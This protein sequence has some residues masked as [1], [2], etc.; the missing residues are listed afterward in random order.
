MGLFGGSSSSSSSLTNSITFNPNI[1]VGE[2]NTAENRS[3]QKASSE[4][5][6]TTKDEFGLSAGVAF[7]G[8]D[9]MGGAVSDTDTQ[10]MAKPQ[11]DFF[12]DDKTKLYLIGG[13]A[14]VLLFGG[15][16]L[17][18]KRKKRK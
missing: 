10:P 14:L 8:G 6:A 3:E 9:A 1:I 16:K 17:L 11:F 4:A 12:A 2:D 5:S 15:Y 18:K 7:G 13:G